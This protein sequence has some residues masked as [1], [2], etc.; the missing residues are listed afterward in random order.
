MNAGHWQLRSFVDSPKQNEL[1]YLGG[2]DIYQINTSTLVREIVDTL[3]FPPR[4]LT[5]TNGWI[6]CGGDHGK[7]SALRLEAKEPSQ[8]LPSEADD[9][10]PLGFD[11]F[12]RPPLGFSGRRGEADTTQ[13]PSQVRIIGSEILNC[14]TLWFPGPD[15]AEKS[16]TKPVA[17]VASN[18]HSIYIINLETLE[19]IQRLEE[20]EPV[21][22]GRISPD[23]AL[24]IVVGDDAFMH[25]YKR[26]RQRGP[27][28]GAGHN[29][30]SK[31][32]SIQLPGQ[33]IGD[34]DEMRGSFTG[35]FS[36]RY[37]AV[38]TQ[39]GVIAVFETQDL[40]SSEDARPIMTFTTTRPG[41]K[42]GAIRS[43]QF[44]PSGL[45]D[46]LAVTEDDGRVIIADVRQFSKR[47]VIDMDPAMEDLQA[48]ILTERIADSLADPRLQADP[49]DEASENFLDRYN[50][51]PLSR[52]SHDSH[53][54]TREETE[55]LEAMQIERR[56][57]EREVNANS[58]N[59]TWNDVADEL[60][61][62]VRGTSDRNR[63]PTSVPGSLRELISNRN[64]DSLRACK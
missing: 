34:Q 56:R 18:D 61:S 42:D 62:R 33:R 50:Q 52:I 12:I 60:H 13:L 38:G 8:N 64:N 40:I 49:E 46:L 3:P 29:S 11:S 51:S 7:F 19:V 28:K 31:Y 2:R 59:V 55:V 20:E 6:C 58:S 9:P 22:L 30:W 23:G 25:V 47:Q 5:S 41:C 27:T 54:L 17:V 4:C 44:N 53:Q 39:Y 35:A 26:K 16:Y 43:L 32:S 24:L 21:N 10:L 63:L 15:T 45:L 14:I 37:L 48:I 36:E 1:H 57:R